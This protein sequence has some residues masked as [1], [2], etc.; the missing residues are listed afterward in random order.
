TQPISYPLHA[1]VPK[2]LAQHLGDVKWDQGYARVVHADPVV[3]FRVLVPARAT[4]HI[5]YSVE[6]SGITAG[7]FN[8]WR[9]DEVLAQKADFAESKVKPQA[10][11]LALSL[12]ATGCAI[13]SS[14][15]CALSLD[16]TPTL[17]LV[18]HVTA[19][20]KAVA[21]DAVVYTSSDPT[22]LRVGPT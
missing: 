5:T 9:R 4:R 7:L 10:P 6:H 13:P 15:P 16:S 21:A 11:K 8:L 18:A 14:T 1:V 20:G 22:V 19:D 3:E 17:Q 12:T 2:S